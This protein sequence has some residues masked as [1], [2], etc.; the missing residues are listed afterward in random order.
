MII[1]IMIWSLYNQKLLR[2][3]LKITHIDRIKK[4]NS[5]IDQ[6]L[7]SVTSYKEKKGVIPK[8]MGVS[9]VFQLTVILFVYL[10]S[11]TIGFNIPLIY[12]CMFVPLISLLEAIPASIY[13]VGL[14]DAGYVIFFMQVGR[15]REDALTMALLYVAVTL[16]YALVGGIVFVV[17]K[18]QER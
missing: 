16:L 14:R 13:G 11:T 6:F 12:F 5:M 17:K 4:V 2:W 7:D 1:V 8:I 15:T 9:F 18:R 3:G 10:L